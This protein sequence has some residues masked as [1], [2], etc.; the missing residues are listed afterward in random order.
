MI[1]NDQSVFP[2]LNLDANDGWEKLIGL[3]EGFLDMRGLSRLRAVLDGE[4]E[5]IIVERE[6]IDKD[7]RDTFTNFHAKR[8]NTPPSRCVRLHFF[9]KPIPKALMESPDGGFPDGNDYLGYSVIR[10]TRPNSVGRTFLS[11]N[12]RKDSE[13]HLCL[14]KEKV[15]F[16]GEKLTIEGFPF[17]SQDADATVCAESS[18]WMILRYLSN[19]YSHYAE[20]LPFQ[21]TKLAGNHALGNRVFP[22]AGLY[23]WQLAEAL[24]LRGV[25][26]V[27][28]SRAQFG[29][30]FE[31]LLYTY[32]ES[33]FPLLTTVNGHVF[34]SFGHTSKFG[35][36]PA[37]VAGGF[38][39][40]SCFN[41]ALTI[42]DDNR[43]PYESLQKNGGGGSGLSSKFK[44]ADI[45][46]FIV[47]LPEKVFLP[48]EAAQE[49]IE[50]VL[51][52][53]QTGIS[54]L[55]PSLDS[56][57]LTL[58]LFLTTGK[59]LKSKLRERGMG[60]ELVATVYRQIPLPHFIWVCEISVTS[61]YIF[62]L[63]VQ[64]EILWDATRNAHE[65]NGWLALHYP[66]L[67]IVDIGG[68]FNGSQ[69][70]ENFPLLN[71]APYPLF[72]SNLN[73]LKVP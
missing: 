29:A 71:S 36:N 16:L 40:T 60:H 1:Y 10:A 5:S 38:R 42:C 51:N 56:K 35:T 63:T 3:S 9:A 54:K 47:P 64:G 24:K 26:P 14:C 23:T 17:I 50:K 66:E 55:S 45:E 58:R 57:D 44:F 30:E 46:E 20:S 13:S 22:S 68:V 21:I 32:I 33:G 2:V 52:D 49:A 34:V 67:L 6:Y 7:Y 70:L 28:Y 11:H 39:Y 53:P 43:F 59:A 48:A 25:S 18:L 73:P 27:I 72:R 19:R 69:K 12:L 37:P 8:F 61:E 65:P 4:C 62:D 41:E 31:H 15:Q